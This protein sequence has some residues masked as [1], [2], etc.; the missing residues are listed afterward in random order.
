M[1]ILFGGCDSGNKNVQKKN[2]RSRRWWQIIVSKIHSGCCLKVY[3]SSFTVLMASIRL[4]HEESLSVIQRKLYRSLERSRKSSTR[5]WFPRG[6]S[7]QAGAR[8]VT[9]SN[10]ALKSTSVPKSSRCHKTSTIYTK[11]Q[12]CR[13]YCLQNP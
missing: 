12:N 5:T 2:K 13:K 9:Y 4:V 6:L 1:I 7:Y 3:I 10:E 8:V 11:L